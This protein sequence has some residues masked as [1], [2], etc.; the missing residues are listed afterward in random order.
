MP[1]SL[2]RAAAWTCCVE[3]GHYG[4]LARKATWLLFVGDT[5]PPAMTWGTSG[6]RLKLEDSYHSAEERRRAVKTGR[7]Q[8]L[9]ARQRAATPAAFAEALIGIA[10]LAIRSEAS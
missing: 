8:R 1:A 10:R 2:F 6:Q 3:Q 9:S 5:E 4:H 7:C